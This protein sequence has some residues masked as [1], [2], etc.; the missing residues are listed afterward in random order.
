[1]RPVATSARRAR[2]CATI[3]ASG[4]FCNNRPVHDHSIDPADEARHEPTDDRFWNESYYFDFHDDAGELGGYI[5][6]GLYPNLGLT[7]YWACVVGAGRPLVTLIDAAAPLPSPGDLDV[8]GKAFTARHRCEEPTRRFHVEVEG[9]AMSLADP[10]EVYRALGGTR[11]PI[12]LDLRWE[13]DGPGGYRFRDLARYEIPCDVRG[14]IAVGAETFAFA[15]HGQ[16]DHSWGVRDWWAHAWCWNAGRLEDG[17]RFHS[18]APRTLAGEKLPW[19]AG[20]VQPPGE[21]LEPISTSS[22]RESLGA[23]GLPTAG[24]IEV[25][26]LH[27]AVAP[28]FFSPVLLTD[29]D[30]RVSR[31]PRCLARFSDNSGRAGFGWIEW[32]QPQDV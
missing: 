12:A 1:M 8:T 10:A 23:N 11:S 20:Y 24:R 6:V 16:R 18:V 30:G 31:F 25:G 14:T 26:A 28:R 22:A 5:R 32:N 3:V 17:T 13:T 2:A 7:W 9:G 15:G 29:P 19:A 4:E 21:P 27:L